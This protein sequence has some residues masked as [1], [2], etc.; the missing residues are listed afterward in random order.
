[1]IRVFYKTHRLLIITILLTLLHFAV[2][3]IYG[4]YIADKAGAE[5]GHVAAQGLTKAYASSGSFAKAAADIYE[6]MKTQ[7]KDQFRFRGKIVDN[8]ANL[9][10]SISFGLILYLLLRIWSWKKERPDLG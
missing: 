4:R 7:R 3:S 9:V 8:L 6:G 1:M 10:N 5:M 2:S